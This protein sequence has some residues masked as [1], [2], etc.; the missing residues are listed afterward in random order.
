MREAVNV[1]VRKAIGAD[2]TGMTWT[3]VMETYVEDEDRVTE[4]DK[5]FD[6]VLK[7]LY[8]WALAR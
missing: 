6:S 5:V 1:R 7:S 2:Q 8:C 3:F 4:H